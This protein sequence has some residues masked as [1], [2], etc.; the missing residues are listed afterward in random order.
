MK[1]GL[2]ER[3]SGVND[4][5]TRTSLLAKTGL[6]RQAAVCA[7]SN[8]VSVARTATSANFEVRNVEMQGLKHDLAVPHANCWA[9]LLLFCT[10]NEIT[11]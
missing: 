9:W 6:S 5:F 1:C 11:T 2:H 10:N 4:C 3:W 8:W 7:K